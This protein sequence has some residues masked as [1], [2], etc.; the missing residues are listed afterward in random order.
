MRVIPVLDIRRGQAVRA[1]AGR[2]AHYGP[3][4]S[5]LHDGTDPIALARAGRDAW[6]LLD[7]YLADLDA[8]LGEAPPSLDLFRAIHDLGLSPWVDAGVRDP[9]DVPALIGAGVERVIVGLETIRG[10]ETIAEIVDEFGAD[11]IVFS[12]DLHEGRPLV[13]TSAGWGTGIGREIAARV[14]DLGIRRIIH[15]DL[16]HVGTGQRPQTQSL[17]WLTD[18]ARSNFGVEWLVGGGIDTPEDLAALARLGAW[19]V[20]VGS[21]LH[22]GR[23]TAEVLEGMKPNWRDRES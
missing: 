20:L 18:L 7:L 4:R 8:I 11:R 12:L 10:P 9:A 2:R 21:A 22:D 15:L 3:L 16:A 14:I 17:D 19:G 5:V 1:V 23:M 6:A 13:E